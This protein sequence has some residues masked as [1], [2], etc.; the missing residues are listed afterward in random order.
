MVVVLWLVRGLVVEGRRRGK[1]V[2]EG[3]KKEKI[4]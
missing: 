4:T 2:E 3:K 1:R